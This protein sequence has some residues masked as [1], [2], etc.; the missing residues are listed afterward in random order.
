[1]STAGKTYCST[2]RQSVSAL[3]GLLTGEIIRCRAGPAT[4]STSTTEEPSAGWQRWRKSFGVGVPEK[5][6]GLSLQ[7]IHA[8]RPL[9]LFRSLG[10]ALE[11]KQGVGVTGR[12]AA[13]PDPR[14]AAEKGP[15]Q[16]TTCSGIASRRNRAPEN[17]QQKCGGPFEKSR[18]A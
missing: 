8:L 17:T 16:E 4:L 1:M 2:S 13:R 6:R 5:L 12:S 18:D 11:V 7:N 14:I 9:S 3:A 15:D 10:F